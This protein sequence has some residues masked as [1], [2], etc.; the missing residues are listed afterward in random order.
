MSSIFGRRQTP[1][2]GSSALWAGLA[3]FAGVGVLVVAVILLLAMSKKNPPPATNDTPPVVASSSAAAP[4]TPIPERHWTALRSGPGGSRVPEAAA[5]A[6]SGRFR[7][8]GTFIVLG[9]TAYR[10]AI[11]DDTK[12][13]DQYLVAEDE[14]AGPALVLRVQPDRVTI[15]LEGRTEELTLDYESAVVSKPSTG[16]LAPGTDTEAPP[17]ETNAYG[18]RT[19]EDRWVISHEALT[20]YYLDLL[21]HPDRAA[22]L[23]RNFKPDMVDN[24]VKGYRLDIE[25]EGD[26]LNAV[27]LKNGDV[28]RQVN[29]MN[30]TSQSRAEYF[31]KEVLTQN[32]GA[33]VLDI[34]RD[35]EKK[36]LVYLME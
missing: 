21:D 16:I 28:V 33:I 30:M 18:R 15:Q 1:A 32:L 19:Q 13:G 14:R 17:L 7:L 4:D 35:G 5:A 11:L 23:Y 25:G 12:T 9:Q 3:V 36:K 29:S 2:H 31:I 10:K 27:G 24:A 6:S 34:E 26:F 20:K 22:Q 8:A